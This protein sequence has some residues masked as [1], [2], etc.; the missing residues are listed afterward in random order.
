MGLWATLIGGA[1]LAGLLW[2]QTERVSVA[3][4]KLDAVKLTNQALIDSKAK[5]EVQIHACKMVNASNSAEREA[6]QAAAEKA[7]IKLADMTIKTEQTI[8][9][10]LKQAEVMR[11]EKDTTCRTLA[12]PL[13][14]DF[15]DWVCNK[16]SGCVLLRAGND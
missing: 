3:H 14:N 15:I 5:A 4:E 7:R 1:V 6:S 8:S 12:E 9:D 16:A 11:N 2:L 13:P 10:T